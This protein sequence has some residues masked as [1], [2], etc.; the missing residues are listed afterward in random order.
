MVSG[1]S[2]DRYGIRGS[3]ATWQARF[4]Q[5]L[6][7]QDL[8]F[9]VKR[10]PVSKR[11][12]FD[13]PYDMFSKGFTVEEVAEKPD[14]EWS[15]EVAKVLDD[16]NATAAIRQ[17]FIFE[18]LFGWAV[19]AI[20]YVDYGAD[21]SQ[22]VESPRE[23]RE[24]V[25]YTSFTCNVAYS[26]ED[27]DENSP[28]FGLPVLYTFRRSTTMGLEKKFHYSR[29]IHC[30]TRL[31]DHPWKGL[32]C[33]EVIYDDSTVYRNERWALGETL[34][35][36]GSGFP[37]ITL[38]GAKKKQLDDFENSQQFRALN[39]RTHFVHDDKSTLD[40]KGINGKAVNPEPYITST[41]ES[42]SCGARIPVSHLR[43]ANAGALPGAKLMT[44]NIGVE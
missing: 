20:T 40:F 42:M 17:L 7:E 35:R 2:T 31:L 27:K 15:R 38:N 6:N 30:A 4:G 25:P 26:D 8:L 44:V 34:V 1:N 16:L 5:P 43:G 14:P 24:L 32:S 12:V 19:L 13:V 22:P 9:S 23:I 36:Y 11:L 39:A 21:P 33:L 41:L 28:R 18:R 3:G 29:A 37:D 10:E